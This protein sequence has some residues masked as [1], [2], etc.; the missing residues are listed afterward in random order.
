VKSSTTEKPIAVFFT[1]ERPSYYGSPPKGGIRIPMTAFRCSPQFSTRLVTDMLAAVNE[2]KDRHVPSR[3]LDGLLR[4]WVKTDCDLEK[5]AM[6]NPNE[7]YALRKTCEEWRVTP[8]EDPVPQSGR[9]RPALTGALGL[10]SS[11]EPRDH[12]EER[13]AYDTFAAFV[14]TSSKIRI[15]ICDRCEELYWSNRRPLNKRFC[16]RKCSQLQTAKEG[17]AKRLAGERR[18]KNKRIR[19]T[20]TVF[21]EEKPAVTDWKPWV[22]S[23]ARVT[24]S[25]LTRALNKGLRG[26]RDGFK[27]TKAQIQYLESK[28]E[29]RHA[30]LQ[31]RVH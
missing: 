22:A 5:W 16:G 10:D 1:V 24:R 9:Y 29:T 13:V 27:L 7:F 8:F 21:V 28:G 17:Q 15:G 30:N 2:F 19:Q 23:R 26:E 4:S 3:H 6:A 14:L 31:A 12:A 20:L 25:Y 11:A 18:D